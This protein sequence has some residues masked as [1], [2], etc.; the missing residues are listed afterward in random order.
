MG[1]TAGYREVPR[2]LAIAPVAGLGR[3]VGAVA[4]M[5]DALG[6]DV[7]AGLVDADDQ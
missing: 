3:V 1:R 4:D 7:E 6:Y 2:R 5:A